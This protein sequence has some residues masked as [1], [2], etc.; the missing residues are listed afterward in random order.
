MSSSETG[1]ARPPSG[2]HPSGLLRPRR[3][4]RQVIAALLLAALGFGL[5]V[6]VRATQDAGLSSLRQS[7]LIR[8]LDDVTER[9]ARLQAETRELERTR[10]RLRN[11][12]DGRRTALEET[13]K[14]AETLGIL[15]GTLP[16]TGPGIELLVPDPK[17]SV[18][19]LLLLDAVQELRDA[20]A[21]AMQISDVR[22]VASTAFT[23]GDGAILIDGV[24]VTAPYRVL[25]VGEPAA[26]ATALRIPGGVIDTLAE[27]GSSAVVTERDQL[28][29]SALHAVTT[30][31]YARPAP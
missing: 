2:E 26:L 13:R 6:Q 16:A 19:P 10:D 28:T 4:P 12:S 21:E 9:S 17:A 18:G 1:P 11:S 22:V 27:Q 3:T 23:E 8:I 29:V 15:A 24:P 30:P 31:E 20:G 14:R 25:A 7:D 5:V